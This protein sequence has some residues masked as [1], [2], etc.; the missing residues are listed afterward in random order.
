VLSEKPLATT[1]EQCQRI[2]DAEQRT[3]Q[4]VRVGFNA[5]HMES[6]EEI[7][8]TLRSGEIGRIVSA[9]FDEYLDVYHGASYFR[10]WHGKKRYSGSLLV[11]KTSRHFDKMN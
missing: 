7:M 10:R 5:R 8:R 2:L 1:A 11:H 9:E 3:D 6:A 4:A